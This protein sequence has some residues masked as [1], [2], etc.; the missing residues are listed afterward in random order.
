M[1]SDRANNNLSS[2]ANGTCTLLSHQLARLGADIATGTLRGEAFQPRAWFETTARL[3]L[4]SAETL[5]TVLPGKPGLAA[6]ELANK[7]RVWSLFSYADRFLSM[8][9]DG[10]FD[11]MAEDVSQQDP[12]AAVWLTEGWGCSY[13]RNALSNNHCRGLLNRNNINRLPVRFLVPLH[14]GSGIA[15]AESALRQVDAPS[16]LEKLQRLWQRCVENACESYAEMTFEALGLVAILLFPQWV[17]AIEKELGLFAEHLIPY[18]WHGVGRGLYFLPSTFV[19]LSATR[20]AALDMAQRLTTTEQG[21]TNALAGFAWAM[22]LVN[23]QHPQVIAES[24]NDHAGQIGNFC[25]FSNGIVSAMTLWRVLA[26]DTLQ[27]DRWQGSQNSHNTWNLPVPGRCQVPHSRG[28]FPSN[29]FRVPAD[30]PCWV[31]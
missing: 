10:A 9:L 18:F 4:L 22:T 26:P 12:F 11:Q 20:G 2:R 3:G 7:L 5:A 31:S 21:R 14:T 23:I 1:A 25:G 24:L 28:E 13:A 15:F 8:S 16:L 30:G 29:L 27:Q 6:Q 17:T 19:P